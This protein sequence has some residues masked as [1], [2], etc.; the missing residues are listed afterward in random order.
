MFSIYNYIRPGFLPENIVS[1]ATPVYI[2][3]RHP[4]L[5]VVM[6]QKFTTG[7]ATGCNFLTVNHVPFG[8]VEQS[9]SSAVER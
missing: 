3:V 4:N 5:G 2:W 9:L 8:V 7:A 1:A 6:G